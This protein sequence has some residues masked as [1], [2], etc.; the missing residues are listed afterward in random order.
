MSKTL[1]I[2]PS[3]PPFFSCPTFTSPDCGPHIGKK[4]SL[5]AFRQI[6][7]K[8]LPA[9]EHNHALFQKSH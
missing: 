4:I 9:Q 6:L 5:A 2:P 7:Q 3:D 1:K 8:I